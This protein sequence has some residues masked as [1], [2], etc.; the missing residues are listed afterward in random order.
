MEK[1]VEGGRRKMKGGEGGRRVEK[2]VEGLIR[3][4]KGGEG[5]RRMEG[6]MK[7]GKGR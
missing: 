5:R 4:M 6:K 2:E 7:N 3:K 1:E